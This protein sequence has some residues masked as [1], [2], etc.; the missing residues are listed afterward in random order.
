L[1]GLSLS[2]LDPIGGV[3]ETQ[4]NAI[5]PIHYHYGLNYGPSSIVCYRTWELGTQL[6]LKRQGGAS[7]AGGN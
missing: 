3:R 7:P 1:T 2:P 5:E 4:D 6:E